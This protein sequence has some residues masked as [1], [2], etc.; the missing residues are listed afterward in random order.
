MIK[1]KILRRIA[2]LI[3]LIVLITSTVNTTY[4]FIVTS[5]DPITNI[6]V[7]DDVRASGL[8]L[9]KTVE[10]PYGADYKIPDNIS[11]DFKIELGSYYANAKLT[12]TAG[13]MTADANGN[14]NVTVKP[15][16]TLGIE[17]LEE[18]TVV[19]VTEQAT[20][21]KGFAVKGEST[22]Q[23]TVGADGSASI[24]FVNTYTPENVQPTNVTVSG[25]KI[26]EGRE[27]QEGDSFSFKLEQQT[28]D[29]WTELGTKT[30]T[31]SADNADFDKFDFS[32]FIQ[33]LT[34]D[35]VGIY[36]FRMSEIVGDIDVDYD[37]TVNHFT[38]KVTDVD[39]DGK[40]EISTASG[41]ENAKVTEANGNYIVS[42][43]FNNTFVP[44]VIVDPDPI[45]VQIDVNKVLTNTGNIKTGLDGFEFVL[46]NVATSEKLSQISDDNGKA[47]FALTFTKADVG[48]TYTYKLSE[49]NQGFTG[50]TYDTD[51]YKIKVSISLNDENQ[52]VAS[53]TVDDAPVESVVAEFQ[54]VYHADETVSPPTGDNSHV[55]FWFI[56]MI[57]SGA[58]LVSLIIYDRKRARV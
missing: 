3:S 35:K 22:Q 46:E 57:V 44:P 2:M 25:V 4:G 31:Y 1:D 10:H 9:D 16:V 24:R 56:L 29:S 45:T 20:T 48:N 7:P 37:K 55:T 43:T 40:L 17:G 54:N 5:T 30:V 27:W 18:G 28:G 32:D 52:L 26:L 13:E 11:F 23:I 47:A 41:T 15:G 12:T 42:V 34:F 33:P 49:T 36:T 6:F 14:L 21:L 39:M 38:V 50:M 19:K 58:T 51:V 53:L 8:T